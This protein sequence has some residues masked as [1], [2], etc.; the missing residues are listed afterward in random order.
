MDNQSQSETT[1]QEIRDPNGRLLKTIAM[2]NGIPH[3]EMV[4]FDENEKTACKLNYENGLLSG[5]AEFFLAEQPLMLTFF[6]NGVQEGETTFFSNGVKVGTVNFL[7]GAFEGEFTSFDGEG[8]VI[9]TAAYSGGL[10]NGECKAF[11][12]DGVLMEHSFYRNNLL[13]G[14]KIK[15]FPNGNVMEVS[16]FQDGKPCGFIDIYDNDGNLKSSREV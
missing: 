5:P 4:I 9:R 12:P 13:Q 1:V 16:S 8:N 7:N 2:K 6:K 15:Y 3:G 10:Q 14:E 11:Y